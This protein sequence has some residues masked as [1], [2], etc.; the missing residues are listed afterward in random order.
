MEDGHI[1]YNLDLKPNDLTLGADVK[2]PTLDGQ[3]KLRIPQ[4]IQPNT[5]LKIKG[6]GP[7]LQLLL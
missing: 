3:E 6:K 1:A 4:G 5:I 7:P 2:V